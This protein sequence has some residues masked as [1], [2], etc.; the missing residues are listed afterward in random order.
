[1]VT[2]NYEA[3]VG[4][5]WCMVG[6]VCWQGNWPVLMACLGGTELGV[7]AALLIL[8]YEANKQHKVPLWLPC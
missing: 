7:F 2:S 6:W 4:S 1:M 5:D 3:K 8:I